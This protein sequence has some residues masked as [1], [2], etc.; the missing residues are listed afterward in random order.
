[1]F[2]FP[3]LVPMR[4]DHGGPKNLRTFIGG[5]KWIIFIT[6]NDMYFRTFCGDFVLLYKEV[7]IY[8][9]NKV[10]NYRFFK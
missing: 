5:S 6:L 3:L 4:Y 1:M 8:W 9:L 2:V 7:D 10:E